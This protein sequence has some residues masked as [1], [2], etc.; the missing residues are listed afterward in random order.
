MR[1]FQEAEFR[2]LEGHDHRDQPIGRGNIGK[3]GCSQH[4]EV[5]GKR[6]QEDLRGQFP[7]QRPG[8]GRFQIPAVQ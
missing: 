2:P 1:T 5:F 3:V 4:S 7:L 6:L 8:F